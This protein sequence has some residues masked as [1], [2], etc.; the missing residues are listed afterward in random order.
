[1]PGWK[2]PT[3]KPGTLTGTVTLDVSAAA[4]DITARLTT[5][6]RQLDAL[7]DEIGRVQRTLDHRVTLDFAVGPIIEQPHD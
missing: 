7:R 5:L 1:M 2:P 4:A 6:S 3:L